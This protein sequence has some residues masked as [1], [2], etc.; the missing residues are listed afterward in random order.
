MIDHKAVKLGKAA[1]RRDHR[2]LRLAEYLTPALPPVP[3]SASFAGA[4][5]TG[6]WGMF[7]N[8]TLGD[9]TC[10]A[11]AH[12]LMQWTG[13]AGALV[14]PT[15]ADILAAYA[16]ITGYTPSD[17]DSDGGAV[18]LDV[19]NYWRATGI[20]GHKIGAYASVN[21]KNHAHVQA[22]A[23]LFGGL[24]IGVALPL[25]AQGQQTWDVVGDGKTGDSA[26]GSWGGHAVEVVAY[27]AGGLWVVTWGALMRVTW[28][29]WDA[30]VDEA[31]AILSPDFIEGNGNTPEGFAL[32]ALQADLAGVTN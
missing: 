29:F 4:V 15:D 8:D 22:A 18:E 1:P 27:D 5:P 30:Y 12:L 3:P 24:Y 13:S 17:P 9:C 11:A 25:S 7:M 14:T 20:A 32:A 28:A 6:N 19:L 31:Y 23:Y 10:A 2:T 16:A 21:P 26:P